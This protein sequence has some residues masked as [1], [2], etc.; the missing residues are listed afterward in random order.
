MKESELRQIIKEELKQVISEQITDKAILD[1]LASLKGLNTTRFDA[2]E[3]FTED[4][5]GINADDAERAWDKSGVSN[6]YDDFLEF[7]SNATQA[8]LNKFKSYLMAK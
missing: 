1:A 4:L 7:A 3:A 5:I 8:D 2:F 6:R